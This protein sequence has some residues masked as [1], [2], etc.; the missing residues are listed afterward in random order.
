MP[1]RQCVRGIAT[2]EPRGDEVIE[3][4]SYRLAE[5]GL[6]DDR[7]KCLP[8]RRERRDDLQDGPL[9]RL[10]ERHPA[11]DRFGEITRQHERARV[12][13]QSPAALA[14]RQRAPRDEQLEQRLDSSREPA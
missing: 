1:Q 2:H 4:G 12:S 6:D 7:R 14:E 10:E 13:E 11:R 5:R 3:R 8:R 9:G